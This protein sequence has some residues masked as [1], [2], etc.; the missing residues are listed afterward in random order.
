MFTLSHVTQVKCVHLTDRPNS[1]ATA[2]NLCVLYKYDTGKSLGGSE[3]HI[4]LTGT[5]LYHLNPLLMRDVFIK[6]FQITVNQD[7]CALIY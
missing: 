2:I 7:V 5:C 4:E 6:E 3:L 1:S